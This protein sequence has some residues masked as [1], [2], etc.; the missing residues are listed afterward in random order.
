MV[1]KPPPPPQGEKHSKKALT[2]RK[3]AKRHPY[4]EKTWVDF[5]S[6]ATAYSW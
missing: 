4:S 5:P 3:V 1:E 6:G 2:W